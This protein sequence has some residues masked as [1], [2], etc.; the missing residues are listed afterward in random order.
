MRWKGY[1]GWFG[2]LGYLLLP[3]L[4]G[5]ACVP[6]RR[7]KILSMEEGE[8]TSSASALAAQDQRSGHRFVLTLLP[9][10]MLFIAGSF[11]WP[12]PDIDAAQW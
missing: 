3:G 12:I 5:V 11:H 9:L 1:S 2:F 6:D 10:V 4:I 8:A 7:R